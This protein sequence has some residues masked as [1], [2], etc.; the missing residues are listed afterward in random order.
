[1]LNLDWRVSTAKENNCLLTLY[2]YGFSFFPN[3]I[4][5]VIST[6]IFPIFISGRKIH[7][8]I[9]LDDGVFLGFFAY[10][11]VI[12]YAVFRADTDLR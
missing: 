2:V 9:I 5:V 4:V 12:V 6:S 10:F 3:Y 7:L 1:V 11:F 8:L